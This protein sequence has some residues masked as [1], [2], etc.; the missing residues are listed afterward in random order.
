MARSSRVGARARAWLLRVHGLAGLAAALVLVTVGATGALLAFEAELQAATHPALPERTDRAVASLL[1]L[2]ALIDRVRAQAPARRVHSVELSSRTDIAAR[3][4]LVPLDAEPGARPRPEDRAFVDPH[5]GD[6]LR[7]GDPG[8]AFTEQ[9][10]ALHRWLIVA[11]HG[12]RT[13]GRAITGACAWA[14]VLLAL[15]G[16]CLHWPRK[17]GLRAWLWPA[18]KLRGRAL[19]RNVHAVA[20]TWAMPPLLVMS[21]SGLYWSYDWYRVGLYALAGEPPRAAAGE[22]AANDGGDDAAQHGSVAPDLTA[23]W[24]SFDAG[25][26]SR[27]VTFARWDLSDPAGRTARVRYLD[28]AAAHDRAFSSMVIELA[29]GQALE[30]E[31]FAELPFARR[32][33]RSMLALHSGS[34][35]GLAGRIAFSA[36]SLMLC[37]LAASGVWLYIR[38]R[39][40]MPRAMRDAVHDAAAAST[41][42]PSG[43]FASGGMRR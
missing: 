37:G 5:T 11:G 6:I 35:F 18:R 25:T 8:S 33:V 9:V 16:V 17:R 15:S 4:A 2:P 10:R 43:P 42:A 40:R 26:R 38:A 34:A 31:R 36:A 3:V 29:T 23:A 14:C 41:A 19:W 22:R 7:I 32:Q 39:T 28:A 27:G 1:S 12:D 13:L 20:G 24:A 21:L 30:H